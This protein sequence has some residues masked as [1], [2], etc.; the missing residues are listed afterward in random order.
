LRMKN[1]RRKIERG[2]VCLWCVCVF[3]L[4]WAYTDRR[5]REREGEANEGK[6]HKGGKWETHNAYQR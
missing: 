2:I 3:V 4:V 1:R 5:E 6:L